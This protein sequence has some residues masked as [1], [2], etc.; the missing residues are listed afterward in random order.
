MNE[1]DERLTRHATPAAFARP[2][3]VRWRIVLILMAFSF[4]AHFN[5][6]SMSAAG[7]MR[8]MGQFSLTPTQMGAVYSAFLLFYTLGMTPGGVFIDRYGPWAALVLMGLGSALFCALTGSAGMGLLAAG[9]VWPALLLI[10]SAMGLCN[11][12]VYPAAGRI[13]VWWVPF[14]R[15][16]W[17]NG[18]VI[19]AAPVGVATTY[20]IMG[21]LIDRLDW[22]GAFLV[23][24]AATGAVALGWLLYARDRPAQHPAVNRAELDLIEGDTPDRYA[25]APARVVSGFEATATSFREGAPDRAVASPAGAW[26]DLLRNRSVVLLTL[27][28][29]AG[30]YFEYLFFYWMHYYFVEVLR[31]GKIESQFYAGIPPLAMALTMPLG[32][33]V[34]DRLQEAWG[35]RLGRAV[36]AVAGM[37]AGAGFLGLGLLAGEPAWVVTWFGLALGAMGF[38]EAAAWT[39]AIE[40][41]GRRGGTTAGIVNTGGNLGGTLSPYITPWASGLFGWQWGIGLGGLLCLLGVFCWLGIDPRSRAED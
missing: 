23:T 27:C 26:W 15:R 39:T 8:I 7:D 30:G 21:A 33:W 22:P 11:A 29:M 5:R 9:L 35:H 1:P 34:S 12:P 24:G 25:I 10:R 41:G 2:S 14:S 18:L 32:G 31:L 36:V 6:S 20:L 17:A 38:Y 40:L 13:V 3:W 37:I 28:Y 4:L 19:G 16:A